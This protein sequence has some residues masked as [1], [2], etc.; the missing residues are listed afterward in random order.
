MKY[1]RFTTLHIQVN[2]IKYTH[3][4]VQRPPPSISITSLHL[5]EQTFY[6]LNT[7]AYCHLLLVPRNHHSTLYS[8]R[9]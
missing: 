2:S 9:I 5:V 1:I 3:N 7:N 8:L 6:P 4:V